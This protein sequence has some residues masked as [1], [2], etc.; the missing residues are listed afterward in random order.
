MVKKIKNNTGIPDFE[1]DSLA[2]ILLPK[3][4]KMFESEEVQKEFEVWKA[5]R[6]AGMREST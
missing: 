4:Q 5:T 2:R 1:L 6:E 3:I